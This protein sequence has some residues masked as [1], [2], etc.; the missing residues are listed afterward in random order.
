MEIW[1]R[2]I[3]IAILVGIGVGLASASLDPPTGVRKPGYSINPYMAGGGAWFITIGLL[4]GRR[5]IKRKPKP[6]NEDEE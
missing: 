4:M 1:L 5:K 6:R 2:K 3:A